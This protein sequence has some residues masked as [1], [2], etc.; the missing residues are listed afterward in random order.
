MQ[1]L[2]SYIKEV[3]TLPAAP[4][5]LSELLSL[6]SQEESDASQV[7][8]LI[9]FDPALTAKVLQRC[10]NAAAG[11]GG[12]ITDLN[13]A[14]AKMGFNA[15]FRL[16]ALVIGESMLGKAQKGYGIGPGQLWEHSAMTA[17]A[18]KTLAAKR[19]SLENVAFTA[20]LL[21]DIGKLVLGAFLDDLE[22]SMPKLK[23]PSG[24][25]FLQAEKSVLGAEHAEIGGRVLEGWNFPETLVGAVRN[26]HDPGQD[27]LHEQLAAYV[28]LG[29]VIAH[30]IKHSQKYEFYSGQTQPEALQILEISP[31]E[32]EAFVIETGNVL[33]TSSGFTRTKT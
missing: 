1:A 21:H 22:Q 3:K 27:Q 15:I 17:V 18:A 23:G 12:N 28:H 10:N 6:L 24:L 8:E 11:L 16:V 5:V 29:D 2:D 20:A 33:Q 7:V 4:R 25:S 13:D 32:M 19:G 9:S 30:C 14:V 31:R 26:H